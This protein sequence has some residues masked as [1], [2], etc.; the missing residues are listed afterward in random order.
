MKKFKFTLIHK[1]LYDQEI[2]ANN[3]EEAS[4][5]FNNMIF[6]DQLS[7]DNPDYMESEQFFEEITA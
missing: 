1:Q 2:T 6:E 5:I 4:E 3:F 7:W